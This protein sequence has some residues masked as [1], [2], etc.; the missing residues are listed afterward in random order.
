[1][2]QEYLNKDQAKLCNE[3][4]FAQAREHAAKQAILEDKCIDVWVL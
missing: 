4:F 1:M 3:D 2:D